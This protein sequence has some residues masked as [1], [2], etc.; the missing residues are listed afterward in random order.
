MRHTVKMRLKQVRDLLAAQAKGMIG[1]AKT[2]QFGESILSETENSI[3][4]YDEKVY[5]VTFIRS[6]KLCLPYI[7][8]GLKDFYVPHPAMRDHENDEPLFHNRK[9][10]KMYR[11]KR[12]SEASMCYVEEVERSSLAAAWLFVC[13]AADGM[14][15][16]SSSYNDIKCM[17]RELYADPDG[18]PLA[19][20]KICLKSNYST[21]ES[22]KNNTLS[23]YT[24]TSKHG[25]YRG[26]TIGRFSAKGVTRWVHETK[27]W[28]SQHESNMISKV[29]S[30]DAIH[31]FWCSTYG[32]DL[33]GLRHYSTI[34]CNA[35][36]SHNLMYPR[37]WVG[38][39]TGVHIKYNLITVALLTKAKQWHSM[40]RARDYHMQS[41]S[42]VSRFKKLIESSCD[43]QIMDAV[44][45]LGSFVAQFAKSVKENLPNI[46][47]YM[48]HD[49]MN[50]NIN[51][52]PEGTEDDCCEALVE[53]AFV[54]S[55]MASMHSSNGGVLYDKTMRLI[56][57]VEDRLSGSG[58]RKTMLAK[59]RYKRAGT[60]LKAEEPR[61]INSVMRTTCDMTGMPLDNARKWLASEVA[62]RN[63]AREAIGTRIAGTRFMVNYHEAVFDRISMLTKMCSGFQGKLMPYSGSSE[64][65]RNQIYWH[66]N[67]RSTGGRDGDKTVDDFMGVWPDKD[68]L[69]NLNEYKPNEYNPYKHI[70]GQRELHVSPDYISTVFLRGIS[71]CA[72]I[73]TKA[74]SKPRRIADDI[75]VVDVLRLEDNEGNWNPTDTSIL[76][77]FDR[78]GRKL[79]GEFIVSRPR[80]VVRNPKTG[81]SLAFN[82]EGHRMVNDRSKECKAIVGSDVLNA[83]RKIQDEIN[84]VRMMGA[85][86]DFCDER[87]GSND[88]I[89]GF[90]GDTFNVNSPCFSG[91]ISRIMDDTTMPPSMV[92][93]A[94]KTISDFVR[95]INGCIASKFDLHLIM[96]HTFNTLGMNKLINQCN[97]MVLVKSYMEESGSSDLNMIVTTSGGERM[98]SVISR[99][100]E[101]IMGHTGRSSNFE[102]NAIDNT[103]MILLTT[104]PD[105]SGVSSHIMTEASVCRAIR[106][107]IDGKISDDR[108]ESMFKNLEQCF[109][110]MCT[111]SDFA[112]FIRQFPEFSI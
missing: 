16:D 93:T 70:D 64:Q 111:T 8:F 1:D 56:F 18:K 55:N 105:G 58:K 95:S 39:V 103:P 69:S 65:I 15:K 44:D 88:A 81:F 40:Y 76:K 112:S 71:W 79:H 61:T 90:Y 54:R 53:Y 11:R 108:I 35:R 77:Q 74:F 57:D 28:K 63:I 12:C 33:M 43:N 48:V 67:A 26:A 7:L 31:Q 2:L 9:D 6:G 59:K 107:E 102:F 94:R 47:D 25:G 29:F 22:E 100:D 3:G 73:V 19:S 83:F 78:V 72:G 4:E 66:S 52:H 101:I 87:T 68:T 5:D 86:A 41:K 92:S 106:I 27:R 23:P 96:N 84:A 51:G 89:H 91:N 50:P 38:D 85:F 24:L 82:I 46:Y 32:F 36:D 17:V 37:R 62:G 42:G 109:D 20:A 110:A 10:S 13:M 21:D 99:V 97:T 14:I 60:P 75:E 104:S 34:K 80:T 98:T 49:F 45:L 30:Y